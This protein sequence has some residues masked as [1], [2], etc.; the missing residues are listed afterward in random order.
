L[1]SRETVGAQCYHSWTD[2]AVLKETDELVSCHGEYTQTLTY[3]KCG[4]HHQ[5]GV[6]VA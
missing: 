2:S 1:E 3:S 6:F 4:N 5:F